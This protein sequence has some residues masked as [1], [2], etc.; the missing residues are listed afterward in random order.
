MVI[1][2]LFIIIFS[3][4][5]AVNIF[6]NLFEWPTVTNNIINYIHN[7]N[8]YVAAAIFILIMIISLIILIFEFYRRK[9]K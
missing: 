9:V 8:P 5:T 2:M 1:L 4:V 7:L 6:T 3:I